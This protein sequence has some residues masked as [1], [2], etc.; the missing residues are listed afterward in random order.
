MSSS[1]S[2]GGFASEAIPKKEKKKGRQEL[3]VESDTPERQRVEVM[4]SI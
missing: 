2:G 1:T 3:S 4:V